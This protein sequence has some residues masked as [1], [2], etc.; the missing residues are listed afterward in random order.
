[1]IKPGEM[2]FIVKDTDQ[3]AAAPAPTP[4]PDKPVTDK[5]TR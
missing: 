2:L 3:P 5:P 1:M 4:T